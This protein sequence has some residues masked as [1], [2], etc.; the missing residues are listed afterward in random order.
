MFFRWWTMHT[1]FWLTIRLSELSSWYSAL[2]SS[3]IPAR[4]GL[5][6]QEKVTE[7]LEH[8]QMA[9]LVSHLIGEKY[10]VGYVLKD[11]L[12]CQ[13]KINNSVL[14]KSVFKT[15]HVFGSLFKWLL[16]HLKMDEVQLLYDFI[17]I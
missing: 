1:C 7:G 6:G 9:V 5:V 10:V 4:P 15:L 14:T 12:S 11:M 8:Q 17:W 13:L 3:Y 16:K 2:P